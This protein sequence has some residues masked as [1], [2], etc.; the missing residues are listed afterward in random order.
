MDK[1][2]A[3]SIVWDCPKLEAT[4]MSVNDKMDRELIHLYNG[5]VFSNE[6]ELQLRPATWTNLKDMTSKRSQMSK[7][8]L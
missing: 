1:I 5:M 6:R 3:S 4:Q 7:L 8:H 2:V